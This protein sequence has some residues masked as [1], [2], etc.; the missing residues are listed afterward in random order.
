MA[1]PVKLYQQE[2]HNNLGFYATWLPGDPIEIGDI[3]MLENGR[4]RRETSLLEMGI[5]CDVSTGQS[6]QNLQY[7]STKG[8]EIKTSAGAAATAL[9]KAEI[10]IEFSSEGAFVFN[11]ANLRSR[12]LENR[13]A[14]ARQILEAYKSDKWRKEWLI[15]EALHSAECATIIVSEDRSAGIILVANADIPL[16]AISLSDPK[17]NLTVASTHGRIVHIVGGKRLHPLYSCLRIR[18]TLFGSTSVRPV[19]GLDAD[20]EGVPFSRPGIDELLNS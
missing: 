17:I 18:D 13:T 5:E 10:I 14:V 4:F 15:I 2:M 6:M 11:V 19:R 3:G 20:T 1:S 7:T 12:R 16:P 8:T 9:V